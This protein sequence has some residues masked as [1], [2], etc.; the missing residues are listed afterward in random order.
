MELAEERVLAEL[1]GYAGQLKWAMELDRADRRA[2]KD[3]EEAAVP[4]V[5]SDAPKVI[6]LDEALQD[7]FSRVLDRFRNEFYDSGLADR[8]Y[9]STIERLGVGRSGHELANEPST[10]DL[11]LSLAVL[12]F[13]MRAERLVS[14]FWNDADSR[15]KL[16]RVLFHVRGQLEG[17]PLP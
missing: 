15:E 11:R 12:T 7:E 3:S 13:L 10:C 17:R 14:G 5:Q 9:M 4:S 6:V 2:Q 16:I 8:E 1:A